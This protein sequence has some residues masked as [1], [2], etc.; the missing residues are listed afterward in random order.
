LSA[1]LDDESENWVKIGRYENGNKDDYN[2][3]FPGST[4]N[5][6]T[7]FYSHSV[8]IPANMYFKISFV[9][10]KRF[11][12]NNTYSNVLSFVRTRII[13]A[14]KWLGASPGPRDP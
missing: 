11:G 9:F 8:L 3:D 4:I 6:Q 1:E 2:I 12:T 10:N 14:G 13:R 7:R 5:Y